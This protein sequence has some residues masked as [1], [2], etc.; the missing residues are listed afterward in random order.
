MLVDDQ[1]I[2]KKAFSAVD[3]LLQKLQRMEKNL[4]SFFSRDQRLFT[5]WVDLTF[6]DARREIEALRL[7]Y[8]DLADFHN[9]IHAL[10]EMEDIGLPEASV[11]VREE[12]RLYNEG[13]E[14]DRLHIERLRELRDQF[15]RARIDQDH[16]RAQKRKAARDA[17]DEMNSV[18]APTLDPADLD[19]LEHLDDL[20]NEELE[21]LCADSDVAQMFLGKIIRV[22][23]FTG[24]YRLFFRVWDILHP[25]IQKSFSQQFEKKTGTSLFDVIEKCAKRF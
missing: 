10:A 20:S 23:G 13:S 3:R 15:V 11:I 5:E 16:Q 22:A 8:R 6:R 4:E 18:R 2:R 21:D 14:S 9:W 19:E 24:D 1:Q 12:I 25:K 7:E 17:E